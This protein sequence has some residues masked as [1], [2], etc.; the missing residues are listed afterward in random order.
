MTPAE[1]VN[2]RWSVD[3][4][5]DSLW[6]GRRFRAWCVVDDYSKKSPMIYVDCSISGL[7]MA[8]LLDELAPTRRLAEAIVLDNGPENTSRAMFEWSHKHGIELRFIQQG[9]THPKR[10]RRKFYRQIPR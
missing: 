3:F 7:R 8:I 10:L 5:S 2:K 4:V 6:T 9:Q 1:R